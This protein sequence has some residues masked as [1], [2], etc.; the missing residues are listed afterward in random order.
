[1]ANQSTLAHAEPDTNAFYRRTLHVLNDARVPFLVGGSHALLTYTGIARETKDFDLFLKRDD[2]DAALAALT[3]AGYH[4]EITF[5]HW[6]AKAKHG[7]DVVDLVFSS[8]NGICRVDDG[9]FDHALEADVLGMPVKIAPV[10]ELL[11]Q[12]TFVMERERYD[13]ADVA[14]ILRSQAETLDWD[15][16]VTRF[17]DHWQ[18]LLSYL[19]LFGF[20][21]P[22]ERHRIPSHVIG[23]L[24][25]RLGSVSAAADA[26]RVCR[27]T[28]TSRAQY[29]LD[30]GQYGYRD[31]R[32]APMGNMNPEDVVYWTWAIENIV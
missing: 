3:D 23:E 27:G 5:P 21:Y 18:L 32:L 12:K 11:W 28:L 22:S 8:G 26:D 7:A 13:G 20:I 19:V 10:E 6:L 24:T 17:G 1:M 16:V 25:A 2:L 15:R 31:A 4:T 14:H 30:I 9:W 29:M